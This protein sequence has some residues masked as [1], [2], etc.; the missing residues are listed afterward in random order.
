MKSKAKGFGGSAD[1][2]VAK[3]FK[4]KEDPRI[5]NARK[6]GLDRVP[7]WVKEGAEEVFNPDNLTEDDWAFLAKDCAIMVGVLVD[8]SLPEW[9]KPGGRQIQEEDGS[10][11]GLTFLKHRKTQES[12]GIVLRQA[13]PGV[14]EWHCVEIFTTEAPDCSKVP[15][16]DL[17]SAS[18]LAEKVLNQSAYAFS[19][20]YDGD[21]RGVRAGYA[22]TKDQVGGK[23]EHMTPEGSSMVGPLICSEHPSTVRALTFAYC[24]NKECG[25]L[26]N[27][28]SYDNL[29]SYLK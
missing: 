9:E 26:F 16:K 29:N 22:L 11:T 18:Q 23:A 15:D 3:A 20:N 14:P 12:V 21:S 24:L 7:T 8:Y 27:G 6:L 10:W 4:G 17:D 19:F 28:D 5:T 25:T 13:N 1:E 2:M